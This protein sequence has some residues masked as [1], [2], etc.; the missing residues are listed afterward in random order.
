MEMTM[1]EAIRRAISEAL[2]S[3]QPMALLGQDIVDP[4]AACSG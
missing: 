4:T 3:D 1:S 2:E